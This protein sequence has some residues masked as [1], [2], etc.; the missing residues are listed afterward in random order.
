MPKYEGARSVYI[1]GAFT[2]V[3]KEQ[4]NSVKIL[5]INNKN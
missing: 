5:T 2:G 4:F 3:M 1:K